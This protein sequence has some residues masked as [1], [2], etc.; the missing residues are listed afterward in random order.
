MKNEFDLLNDVIVDFSAYEVKELEEKELNAMK[1]VINKPKKKFWPRVAAVAA[2]VGLI[3]AIGQT[4]FAKEFIGNIVKKISTGHNEFF[5]YD[6]SNAEVDIPKELSIF[7]DENGNLLTKYSDGTVFYDKDGNKIEDV[8]AYIESLPYGIKEA[9]TGGSDITLVIGKEENDPLERY[10]NQGYSIIDNE[11][12]MDILDEALDFTPVLPTELPGSFRFCG[13]AYFDTS[14]YYLTLIYKNDKSE[15]IFVQERLLNE[16]TAF[17]MGTDGEIEELKI[18][19]HKAVLTN[20]ISL[21][22][23]VGDVSVGIAGRGHLNRDELITMAENM[24]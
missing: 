8:Q 20:E 10:R 6:M 14:T 24:K 2:C 15:Y 7:Y 18:N 12:D 23:E 13:A 19:G 17:S 21:D 3:A 16:E 4:S 1:N 5:Q 22:W 11:A 9:V